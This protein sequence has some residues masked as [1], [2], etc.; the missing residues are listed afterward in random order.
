M[1]MKWTGHLDK[2]YFTDVKNVKRKVI[3]DKW[4]MTGDVK[5]QIKTAWDSEIVR[6]NVLRLTAN[7]SE[8]ARS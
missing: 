6:I 1:S 2:W 8:C 5:R 3:G 7:E 4:Q